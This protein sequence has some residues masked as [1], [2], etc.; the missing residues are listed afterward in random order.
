MGLAPLFVGQVMAEVFGAALA[1]TT[2]AAAVFGDLHEAGGQNGFGGT[3]LLHSGEAEPTQEG[4]AFGDDHGV[5]RLSEKYTHLSDIA[6]KNDNAKKRIEPMGCQRRGYG[7]SGAPARGRRRWK[8]CEELL[9][10]Q[11]C[12]A[13]SSVWR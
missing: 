5:L 1:V 4:G 6:S 11:G 12:S 10:P 7:F 2:G 8:Q 9:I 13:S 3:Q